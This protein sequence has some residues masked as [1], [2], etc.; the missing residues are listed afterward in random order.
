MKPV[1]FWARGERNIGGVLPLIVLTNC[2]EIELR[3]GP[4]VKRIGPDRESFPHLPHPPVVIDHRHFTKDE[5]G[6]WGMQWE[7]AHFDGFV[8]GEKVA[9]LHMVA[10]PLPTTMDVKA[11]SRTIRAEGRDSTRVIVRALDQVGSRIPFLNDVVSLKIS[12]PGKIVGPDVIPFQGGT[13]GF[14]LESTGKPGDITVELAS[15]RFA[16]QVLQL[17]AVVSPEEK[18]VHA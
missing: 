1:T 17:T 16:P 3:Y 9:S 15:S 13:T 6:V 11:D 12:G 10:D 18:V 14:W 7:D 2:D 4:I 5:L 8:A